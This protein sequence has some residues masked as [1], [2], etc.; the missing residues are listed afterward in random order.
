[1]SGC[2]ETGLALGMTS[3]SSSPAMAIPIALAY[4][5]AEAAASVATSASCKDCLE[6]V[7]IVAI[8]VAELKLG[9]IQRQVGFADVVIGA[10]DSAFEQAPKRFQIVRMDLAT[11]IFMRLVIDMLMRECLMELLIASRFIG[12]NKA[13][14]GRYGLAHKLRHGFGRS[15]FDDLANHVTFAADRA[16]N[17]G[18][19]RRTAPLHLFVEVAIA[20]QAANIGFINFNLAHQ[21]R[22]ILVLHRSADAL[23]HIPSRPIISAADLPMD[24]QSADALLTLPHQIDD[25]KPRGQRIVGILENR[26]GDDAEPIPVASATFL[27]L[28]DPVEGPRLERIDLG[29]LTAWTLHAIG[30]AHITEQ[31]FAGVLARKIP[32]QFGER[33]VRLCGERLTRGNFVV[34]GEK[35]S[36]YGHGYQ[37]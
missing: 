2:S 16:D 20:V 27:G 19:A 4:A 18:L 22:E 17:C 30:P 3:F 21:L 35:Y 36:N 32:L 9:Q 15:I 1:M 25:L 31:G 13:D 34:H 29:A 23:K 33:D 5:A 8:V 7:R 37:A 26:F 24:L 11:H 14:I 10:D 6:D 12:R 28:A